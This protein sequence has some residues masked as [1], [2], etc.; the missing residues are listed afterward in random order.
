MKYT[1]VFEKKALKSLEALDKTQTRLIL[2]WIDKNLLGMDD[3]RIM[4]KPLSGKFSSYWRYRVGQYRILVEI[5]DKEL[6]IVIITIGHR[7]DV[8]K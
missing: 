4:G 5:L 3:P 6:I 2:A 7:K 1:L 8:Y